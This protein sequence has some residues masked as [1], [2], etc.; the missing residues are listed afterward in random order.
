MTL[1]KST[2][3]NVY[4]SATDYYEAEKYLREALTTYK[5][6]FSGELRFI[7]RSR[8]S[9]GHYITI[10]MQ[11]GRFTKVIENTIKEFGLVPY[12]CPT[13]EEIICCRTRAL[14]R[15]NQH[16]AFSPKSERQDDPVHRKIT[17]CP[18]RFDLREK[19]LVDKLKEWR[20]A[21]YT[22]TIT[23]VPD[24]GYYSLNHKDMPQRLV[25]ICRRL[26]IPAEVSK[27]NPHIV[28]ANMSQLLPR[29]KR[30]KRAKVD[31]IEKT[32]VVVEEP[33]E[34]VKEEEAEPPQ[35][36]QKHERAMTIQEERPR[37]QL[38]TAA[39]ESDAGLI[40]FLREDLEIKFKDF[41]KRPNVVTQRRDAQEGELVLVL[42]LQN[43]SLQS[44]ENYV[45][46]TLL[47]AS[48]YPYLTLQYVTGPVSR[49]PILS[50]PRMRT[51]VL[52]AIQ[53][54]ANSRGIK[55]SYDIPRTN[56]N[57]VICRHTR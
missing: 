24:L 37:A 3:H 28:E 11:N 49:T 21:K 6:M 38:D 8:G 27:T 53:M 19:Q 10:K 12:T 1:K 2:V 40:K 16:P 17:V 9:T 45:W 33:Q 13:N 48:Q 7:P 46:E 25:A 29:R 22:G 18:F 30:K 14:R 51:Q 32:T 20:S 54:L 26:R 34:P 44:A 5:D 50:D 31:T 35:Q 56:Q 39:E 41:P 36:Q 42:D 15:G 52:K 4:L 47:W 43:Y 57:L 23:F 55:Y